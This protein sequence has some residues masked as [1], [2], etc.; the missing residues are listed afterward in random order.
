M[1]NPLQITSQLHYKED[2]TLQKATVECHNPKVTLRRSDSAKY[3]KPSATMRSNYQDCFIKESFLLKPGLNEILLEFVSKKCGTFKV[4]QVSLLVEE[5]LEFLSN[6]L[7]SGNVGFDV[8]TQGVNVYLNKVEP[9]KDLVAG[10]EHAMELVVTSG[11]SAIENVSYFRITIYRYF[12]QMLHKSTSSRIRAI[13]QVVDNTRKIIKKK[14]S[15][16]FKIIVLQKVNE[17]YAPSLVLSITVTT[18][19]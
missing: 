18:N 7:I 14:L 8:V 2:K 11:S 6:A 16:I 4:G 5:K 17:F 13:G 19:L 15:S 10:L 12:I 3:R 1:L 9:K